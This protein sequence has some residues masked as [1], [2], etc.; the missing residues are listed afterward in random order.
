MEYFKM[1][2]HGRRFEDLP[3]PSDVTRGLLFFSI[4]Y[5]NTRMKI[6]CVYSTLIEMHFGIIDLIKKLK[7]NYYTWKENLVVPGGIIQIY[8]YRVVDYIERI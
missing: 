4:I 5:S 2:D 6:G 1:A 3:S 7:T 8:F